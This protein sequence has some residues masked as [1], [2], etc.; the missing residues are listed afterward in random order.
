VRRNAPSSVSA[1][2]YECIQRKPSPARARETAAWP[3]GA[4]SGT[5][6][7][8]STFTDGERAF[9]SRGRWRGLLGRLATVGPDGTPHVPPL[10]VSH[11]PDHEALMIGGHALIDPAVSEGSGPTMRN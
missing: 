4:R 10:P 1:I 2:D 6:A 9:L 11:D 3:G 5:L 7:G 8:I